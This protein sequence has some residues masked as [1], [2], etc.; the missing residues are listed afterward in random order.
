M[1]G[2]LR[3]AK[4]R[5]LSVLVDN[6]EV[7]ATQIAN[8]PQLERTLAKQGVVPQRCGLC[9]HF[10]RETYRRVAA[11]NPAFVEAMRYLDPVKMAGINTGPIPEAPEMPLDEL[12]EPPSALPN[13]APSR[14]SAAALRLRP[15]LVETHEDYG[16]CLYWKA[17]LWGFEEQPAM[18]APTD[19][20]CEKWS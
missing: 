15:R 14:A 16:A 8:N 18:P 11:T 9:K 4:R 2:R 17:A 3:E 5:A 13:P 10:D 12:P 20:P 6:S 1:L 19:K 7:L